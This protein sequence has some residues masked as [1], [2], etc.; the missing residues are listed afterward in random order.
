MAWWVMVVYGG[1]WWCMVVYGGVWRV[2]GAKWCNLPLSVK[3]HDAW[4]RWHCGAHPLRVVTSRMLPK[5]PAGVD[6]AERERQCGLRRKFKGVFDIIQGQ[7]PNSVVDMDVEYVWDVCWHRTVTLFS[8]QQPC[9]WVVSTAY[10]FFRRSPAL[11]EQ[12]KALPTV[13]VVDV[14]LAAAA[15][16]AKVAEDTRAFAEA[17]LQAPAQ[18]RAP[19]AAPIDA[20]PM[21]LPVFSDQAAAAVA[22]A[23]EQVAGPHVARSPLPPPPPVSARRPP[24][25]PPRRRVS[26]PAVSNPAPAP[27][28]FVE[29][30]AG[31]PLNPL[32][33]APTNL[34]MPGAV[35]CALC[36]SSCRTGSWQASHRAMLSHY[37]VHHGSVVQLALTSP[38]VSGPENVVVI[39]SCWCIKGIDG[40]MAASTNKTSSWTPCKRRR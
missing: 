32:W 16:A 24:A 36:C 17:A 2:H 28:P 14:T 12:A 37:R 4:L 10:D 25:A 31:L 1:L 7:T 15:R 35:Q 13:A 6:A 20:L 40:G 5:T 21:P 18:R 34:W 27:D 26:L 11:V 9:D 23:I 8:I 38:N 19:A 22:M 3:L 29:P 33:P 39:E 30:P